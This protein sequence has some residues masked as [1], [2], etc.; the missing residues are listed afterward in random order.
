MST[1]SSM[2]STYCSFGHSPVYGSPCK[3]HKGGLDPS[4]RALSASPPIGSDLP[5][6]RCNARSL[7]QYVLTMPTVCQV[8]LSPAHKFEP[9][10]LSQNGYGPFKAVQIGIDQSRNH[11]GPQ[12]SPV[13]LFPSWFNTIPFSSPCSYR[14]A[15]ALIRFYAQCNWLTQALL[16]PDQAKHLSTHSMKS[17]LLA[18]AGQLNLNLNLEQRAKQGHHK[19]SVQLYS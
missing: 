11:W 8:A 4:Y 12:W 16:T 19:E 10:Y 3:K 17:T 5:S 14:H 7:Q 1:T 2:R 15:L 13:F 6:E 18:A 9:Q